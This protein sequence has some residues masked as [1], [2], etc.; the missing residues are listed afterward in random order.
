MV[1]VSAC[2]LQF[3]AR[4]D[5]LPA[6]G[7]REQ[8]NPGSVNALTHLHRHDVGEVVGLLMR[9]GGGVGDYSGTARVACPLPGGATGRDGRQFRLQLRI[10]DV[11]EGF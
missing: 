3:Y 4:C 5:A 6:R 1:I 10:G 9:Q 2:I 11:V 8:E 7:F